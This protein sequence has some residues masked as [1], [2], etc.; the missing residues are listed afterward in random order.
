MF[1]GDLKFDNVICYHRTHRGSRKA[2]ATVKYGT[3]LSSYKQEVSTENR[4]T[5]VLPY[6][7]VPVY[8]DYTGSIRALRMYGTVN[9]GA[10][11][12]N[13]NV[14]AIFTRVLPV[15]FTYKFARRTGYI[16]PQN[17][18]GSLP[19]GNGYADVESRLVTLG[20]RYVSNHP[21][22]ISPKFSF[23]ID[24]EE[25]LNELQNVELGDEVKV[26]YSPIGYESNHRIT[27]VVYDSVNERYKKITIGERNYSLFDFIKG[28]I[29]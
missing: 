11:P 7:D 4:Y 1:G 16:N 5:H 18:S 9:G 21:E 12:V 15:D 17:Q 20:Q 29:R 19:N 25:A 10:I 3:N 8:K 14:G 6:A 22:L 13:A 28:R 2:V 27:S 23:D 26:V 24:V